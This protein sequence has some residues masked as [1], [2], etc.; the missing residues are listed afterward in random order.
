MEMIAMG[1]RQG[2]HHHRAVL[3]RGRVFGVARQLLEQ[4]QGLELE[5]VELERIACRRH[6]GPFPERVRVLPS[7]RAPR[8]PAAGESGCRAIGPGCGA[9]L[10]I[11]VTGT[12]VP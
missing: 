1:R 5:G 12:W 6:G 4:G 7:S 2:A 9:P 8:K 11:P 3:A 10:Y